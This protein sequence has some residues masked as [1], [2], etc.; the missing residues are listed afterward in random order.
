MR[1]STN[2]GRASSVK[3]AIGI[4]VLIA[5][6]IGLLTFI[7][8]SSLFTK[9][10]PQ[11]FRDGTDT[12]RYAGEI[13]MAPTA[14]GRCRVIAFDNRSEGFWD[15]GLMPCD[16]DPSTQEQGG[17]LGSISKGFRRE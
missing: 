10:A 3:Q 6:A 8:Q 12:D 4:C 14:D 11:T 2:R 9:Q 7:P 5:L 15:K 16:L 17:R 1:S 13:R